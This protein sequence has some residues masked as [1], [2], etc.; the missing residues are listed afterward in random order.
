MRKILLGLLLLAFSVSGAQA[1]KKGVYTGVPWTGLNIAAGGR[2]TNQFLTSDNYLI[3]RVD[4]FGSYMLNLN[5]AGTYLAPNAQ[6]QL[7]V[8]P[9]SM[10]SFISKASQP[11]NNDSPSPFYWNGDHPG[12]QEIV[13]AP[14][15][16]SHMVMFWQ[17]A[18]FYSTD[19][20]AHWTISTSVNCN[21]SVANDAGIKNY[22]A[23]IAFDPQNENIVYGG[24]ATQ[25]LYRSTDGGVTWAV[26]GASF[27]VPSSKGVFA[28]IYDQSGG[29]L[30][31]ASCPGF[32]SGTWNCTKN[33]YATPSG[34][35][36]Y[37]SSDSGQTWAAV[38]ATGAPVG[39]TNPTMYGKILANGT[40]IYID[41]TSGLGSAGHF[42][43]T[44]T[45]G[46]SG[47]WTQSLTTAPP[48]GSGPRAIAIDPN[49]CGTPI[50][51]CRVIAI[52][53]NG[54]LN[55]G[56]ATG[57]TITWSNWSNNPNGL[58]Y[59][60][61][62]PSS[63]LSLAACTGV[64][65][66][67]YNIGTHSLDFDL[68][69]ANKLWTCGSG[70]CFYVTGIGTNSS[71][72]NVVWSS[73]GFNLYL[74]GTP[75]DVLV[76]PGS[77]NVITTGTDSWLFTNP[78]RNNPAVNGGNGVTIKS[79]ATTIGNSGVAQ[80]WNMDY[81]SSNPA[82]VY[83]PVIGEFSG[84]PPGVI[85]WTSNY[86]A[87]WTGFAVASDQTPAFCSG[88]SQNTT[89]PPEQLQSGGLPYNNQGMVAAAT[90][91]NLLYAGNNRQPW[92]TTDGAATWN[93]MSLYAASGNL[94]GDTSY[95][96]IAAGW[97]INATTITVPA[98]ACNNVV[99]GTG[100]N[101][102]GPVPASNGTIGTVQAC[103][104]TTLTVAAPGLTAACT[105]TGGNCNLYLSQW[106]CSGAFFGQQGGAPA[107]SAAADRVNANT[108]Y[109]QY[110]FKQTSGA[111]HPEFGTYKSTNSGVTW[112][113]IT[114][115]SGTGQVFDG[116]T[117]ALLPVP[118]F[119][120]HLF[121]VGSPSVQ[122]LAWL[123]YQTKPATTVGK[124]YFLKDNGGT[125]QV[126]Q[127]V[128][129]V[130]DSGTIC[131]G[132]A[133]AGSS[134]PTIYVIG[135]TSQN[136]G[137]TYNYGFWRSTTFNPNNPTAD[138]QWTAI[139]TNPGNGYP[140]NYAAT[141]GCSASQDNYGEIYVTMAIA[142]GGGNWT[143]GV[144]P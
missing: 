13:A 125:G 49:G 109:F 31:G 10:A 20:G 101:I 92:Y 144:F 68:N 113:Q 122:Q 56:S 37:F 107:R 129:Y 132:K 95:F 100:T 47:T 7:L 26:V 93:R 96:N 134:Y 23:K 71:G 35:G 24:T 79:T 87:N 85:L 64:C 98:G 54:S 135:F 104:G 127:T 88:G 143:W 116:T 83:A 38:T 97:A 17:R 126:W 115:G 75:L 58:T 138:P 51:N 52:G 11:A 5:N 67:G 3:A 60:Y 137:S 133:A 73:Y 14:S 106:C 70:N 141:T 108:F 111:S 118:G 69:T 2:L 62:G 45:G 114:G 61:D 110:G 86:G 78:V 32:V 123:T 39:S 29:T 8:N 99:S 15:N 117:D 48:E 30:S 43:W 22:N 142:E 12:V 55:I 28:I 36:P 130:L 131:L 84:P 139:G 6:W 19:R 119:A 74:L 112:T 42:V 44:Y 50:T 46:L 120:G 4:V 81:A 102:I 140:L 18:F 136:A 103:S 65:T 16:P 121:A 41:D 57:S 66:N 33:I 27:P 40:L 53:A 124:L 128:P 34:S 9:N 76:P 59:N 63:W 80:G 94:I 25:G 72:T 105:N 77:P 89:M 91:C 82:Y 1:F 90:P 21:C